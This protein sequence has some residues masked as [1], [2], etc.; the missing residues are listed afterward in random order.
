MSACL[1]RPDTCHDAQ[2]MWRRCAWVAALLLALPMGHAHAAA[3]AAGAADTAADAAADTA[4]DLTAETSG[5][6]DADDIATVTALEFSQTMLKFPVDVRLFAEG[7]A[8]PAGHYRAD[9]Q[10]NGEWKGRVTIRFALPRP[11]AR[12]AQP[13]F[14]LELLELMGFDL[15]LMDEAT[16]ASLAVGDGGCQPLAQ[17]IPGAMAEYSSTRL[18]LNASAPQILLRREARGYVD[19]ARWD[20]GVTAAT[21]DYAYNGYHSES[22]RGPGRSS[23]YLRLNTGL[24]LGAWRLRYQ[25]SAHHN[26]TSGLSWRGQMAYAERSLPG[27]N[28]RLTLG[29][30]VSDGQVFDSLR[31]RGVRLD[32][33]ERMRP[34]S[35]RGFAPV[36][37]GI[38][39][40]N[41]RVSIYQL[42]RQIYEINVPPGP[43]VIDDLYP[44]GIGGDLLVTITEADGNEHTFTITYASTA[45]LVR[46][47]RTLYTLA[48]GRHD[49]EQLVSAPAF[50]LG[51]LRHGMS[52]SLTG[53]TGLMVAES[54][55]ALSGGLAFNLPVGALAMDVT[56]A[57]TRTE[58]AN[59]RGSSARAT[60]AKI[61]PGIRTNVTLA[62]YRYSSH[63]YYEPGEA[64]RLHDQVLYG[65]ASAPT[66]IQH[67][68]SRL[69]FNANQPLPHG[70]LNITATSQE[71]WTRHGRDT[72]YQLGYNRMFRNFNLGVSASRTY[73]VLQKRWGNQYMLNLSLPLGHE[74]PLRMTS[75]Y[76][77]QSEAQT[78]RNNVSG[79][80]GQQRQL[81]VNAFVSANRTPRQ[82][83]LYSGG[84]NASWA[85]S[86]ARV[87]GNLSANSQGNRQFGASVT[88]S[89]VA[90]GGGVMLAPKLGETIAIIEARDA[91]GARLTRQA[92]D[93]RLN[94]RG[95][96]IANN[97]RPFRENTIGLD[98]AG[99][100]TDVEVGV[101]TLKV[102]PT[103]GAVALLQFATERSYSF[104]LSGRQANGQ[105]LPF[106]AAVYDEEGRNVGYL[107]Q[108]GQALLR[109]Q[110]PEGMLTVRWG[111]D[112]PHTCQF[113][114]RIDG[115]ARAST[116]EFRRVEATCLEVPASK[117]EVARHTPNMSR[118]RQQF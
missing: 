9:V 33:D 89:V 104:I 28:S 107:S 30:T 22:A 36:V 56:F 43:F 25:A 52:N 66:P 38:A 51:T 68:R 3:A 6:G 81:S 41:A 49:N 58:T 27:W 71:Y 69:V 91:H 55:S 2:P 88:G 16:R 74:S 54:Y 102:A 117:Q 31:F 67:V 108:G 83:T 105:Y 19:P 94:R 64:F 18:Q 101:T 42:G 92:G 80:F 26:D 109:V 103:A 78:L 115:Q 110:Q 87:S 32:S 63:G 24:N 73:N 44:T 96:A 46:P 17:L 37:R 35:Q 8:L 86:K 47:G 12:V 77:H 5:S 10:M 114:Y 72:Q 40:S 15:T 29:S 39:Q 60:W 112:Q 57:N 65:D 14:T 61:L 21:L 53:Y 48:A 23:H 113:N 84:A 1:P 116:T 11:Q 50:V 111:I 62:S 45:Q 99:L 4:A 13:C 98:P 20:E 76:A 118:S 79:V 59:Y 95:H 82:G 100:S 93:I 75:S 97:L 7:N 85:A 90:F 34:D 70:M 106:A